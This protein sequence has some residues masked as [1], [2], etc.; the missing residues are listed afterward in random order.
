MNSLKPFNILFLYKSEKILKIYIL[1]NWKFCRG[2]AAGDK[3]S[4]FLKWLELW[5][6]LGSSRV[7]SNF[8]TNTRI[9]KRT[10]KLCWKKKISFYF[11]RFIWQIGFCSDYLSTE[12]WG[13]SSWQ[14]ITWPRNISRRQRHHF[15][16]KL[17]SGNREEDRKDKRENISFSIKPHKGSLFFW[18]L[19]SY[20]FCWT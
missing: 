6:S 13:L 2:R 4:L 18:E 3:L 20:L 7:W 19:L 15:Q 16:T 14:T 10:E 11:F 8:D 17:F 12:S 9:V 1:H 5:T